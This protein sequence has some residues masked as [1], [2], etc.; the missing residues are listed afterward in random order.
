MRTELEPQDIEAIAQRV[1]DLLKPNFLNIGKRSDDTIFNV[2]G[3]A[4]HLKVDASWVYKAVQDNTI[5]YFKCGKYVRFRKSAID[6]YIEKSSLQPT[7]PL[8]LKR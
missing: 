1:C 7:S 8:R 5:P 6:K 3:L 4:E 2:Q